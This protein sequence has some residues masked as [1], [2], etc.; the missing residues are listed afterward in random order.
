MQES[1]D[2]WAKSHKKL[3]NLSDSLK[4]ICRCKNR[5]KINGV[6][7]RDDYQLNTEVLIKFFEKKVQVL[8]KLDPLTNKHERLR[9]LHN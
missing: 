4:K 7:I 2:P 1:V 9:N 3:N 8:R 5:R 6:R